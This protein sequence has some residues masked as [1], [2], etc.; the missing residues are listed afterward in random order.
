MG[1]GQNTKQT[2]TE[3]KAVEEARQKQTEED[4]KTKGNIPEVIEDPESSVILPP[5]T[6]ED[7][8]EV[9]EQPISNFVSN[10]FELVVKNIDKTLVVSIAAA[11]NKNLEKGIS[12][13]TNVEVGIGET[14]NEKSVFAQLDKPVGL[15]QKEVDTSF[16]VR[17]YGKAY[18]FVRCTFADIYTGQ[19]FK[20]LKTVEYEVK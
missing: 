6:V 2:K 1:K 10:S 19:T 4:L 11:H 8:G 20:E 18:I 15:L 16:G 13:L 7:L 5:E 14:P 3:I 17:Y 12:I 9:F